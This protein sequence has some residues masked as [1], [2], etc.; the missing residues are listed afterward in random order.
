MENETRETISM[1]SLGIPKAFG[2]YTFASPIPQIAGQK[3]VLFG[4]SKRNSIFFAAL[5]CFIFSP[6]TTNTKTVGQKQRKPIL[7]PTLTDKEAH[8]TN[9]S[10]KKLAVQWFV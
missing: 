8:T 3:S 9:S 2:I 5:R 6:P 4:N 7:T 1:R 10:Y